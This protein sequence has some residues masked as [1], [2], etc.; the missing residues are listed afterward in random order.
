M[1]TG[2]WS[3]LD[4]Y[5]LIQ[6]SAQITQVFDL[7][8]HKMNREDLGRPLSQP[9]ISGDGMVEQVYENAMLYAPLDD[10][11]HIHLRPLVL[12]LGFV[13]VQPPVEKNPHD[14]LIF[15]ETENGLGHNIPLFF[16]TF[17]A[18]HGGR[19]QAGRPVTELFPVDEGRIY[20]H[21]LKI[22]AWITIPTRKR[23]GACAWWIWAGST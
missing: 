5:W 16:D 20:R 13:A 11:D 7:A 6:R 19:E 3:R 17:I 14:Q 18:D 8:L 4:E 23:T 9:R 12:W 2:L 1:R 21:A 22:T 15:Y 10:L